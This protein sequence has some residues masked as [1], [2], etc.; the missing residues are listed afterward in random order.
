MK[1]FEKYKELLFYMLFGGLTTVVNLVSY[2][3]LRF[4][5]LHYTIA[6]IVAWFLSVLFSYIANRKWV[7]HSQ[8]RTTF[9]ILAEAVAFFAARFA[10]GAIDLAAMFVGYD[11][12]GLPEAPVKV[13]ANV[14]VIIVNFVTSKLL[15]KTK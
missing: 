3:I 4:V 7:F 14:I 8:R 2:Y 10:S 1:F 5:G 6:T 12:A 15:F 13:A 11:M 9:G